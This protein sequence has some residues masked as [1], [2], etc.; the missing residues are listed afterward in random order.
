[1]YMSSLQKLY[2]RH[3]DLVQVDRYEISTSLMTMDLLFLNRLFLSSITYFDQSLLY[4]WVKRRCFISRLFLSSITYFDQT[5]LYIWVK[6]RCFSRSRHYLPFNIISWILLYQKT[7]KE[8]QSDPLITD[9]IREYAHTMKV[10][11]LTNEWR[12]RNPEMRNSTYF[13]HLCLLSYPRFMHALVRTNTGRL[14]IRIMCP[15]WAT[16]LSVDCCSS[17][18]AL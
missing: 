12:K 4:I 11:N 17:E 2:S 1:M 13:W 8:A 18:L 9:S 16:C 3:H 15:S 10:L 5:L 7:C 14:G 6:Q